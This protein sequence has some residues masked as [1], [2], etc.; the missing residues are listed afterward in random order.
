MRCFG[1]DESVIRDLATLFIHLL[2]TVARLFGPGGARS[3]VAE[4]LL[5]KLQLLILNRSRA[6]APDLRPTDRVIVGLCAILMRP[7]HLTRSAIVLKPSTILSFHRAQV[8]RKC[9]L[10]F[11]PKNRGLPGVPPINSARL[12]VL[13]V[14]GEF[15]F[16]AKCE[17]FP[18]L[19]I[20]EELV[21]MNQ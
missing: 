9:R 20:C 4:S 21:T 12:T 6:R 2:V 1:Y 10:L 16:F 13:P 11:T 19:V 7:A 5:V 15:L 14:G 18:S 3:I 8:K 17:R